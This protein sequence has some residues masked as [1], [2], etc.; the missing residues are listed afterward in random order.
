MEYLK[1]SYRNILEIALTVGYES[2]A[3][4]SKAFK[5]L[6]GQSPNAFRQANKVNIASSLQEPGT[7]LPTKIAIPI[8]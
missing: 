7:F 1:Y 5:K 3:A 6:Y 4:F 8:Q 2:T